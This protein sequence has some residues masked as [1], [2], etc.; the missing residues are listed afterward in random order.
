MVERNLE[1]IKCTLIEN[2]TAKTCA[3][4]KKGLTKKKR[5]KTNLLPPQKKTNVWLELLEELQEKKLYQT[6]VNYLNFLILGK[7][8]FNSLLK[9]LMEKR[10]R[11]CDYLSLGYVNEDPRKETEEMINQLSTWKPQSNK[12]KKSI[13]YLFARF[14]SL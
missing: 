12:L 2:I 1:P 6:K 7:V 11:F 4:E 9:L 3:G 14:L 10:C 13:I 5:D 8:L